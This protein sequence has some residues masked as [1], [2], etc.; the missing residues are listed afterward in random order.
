MGQLAVA[1]TTG[2]GRV[3]TISTIS[4]LSMLCRQADVMRRFA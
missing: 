1:G 3:W 2:A 4:G